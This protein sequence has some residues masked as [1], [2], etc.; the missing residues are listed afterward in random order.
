M[1]KLFFVGLLDGWKVHF[2][3][4]ANVDAFFNFINDISN[5]NVIQ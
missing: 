1:I 3:N 2:L 5:I 4:D